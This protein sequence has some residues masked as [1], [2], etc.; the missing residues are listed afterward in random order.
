MK[1]L[2]NKLFFLW[3]A[4]VEY[5]FLF[6]L[7]IILISFSIATINIRKTPPSYPVRAVLYYQDKILNSVFISLKSQ[8]FKKCIE[9][10]SQFVLVDFFRSHEVSE[11]IF[12]DRDLVRTL[13]ISEWNPTALR[14]EKPPRSKRRTLISN[15]KSSLTGWSPTYVEP[16]VARLREKLLGFVTI[17]LEDSGRIIYLIGRTLDPKTTI[18]VM[19]VLVNAFNQALIM[20]CKAN[21]TNWG[22][23][24]TAVNGHSKLINRKLAKAINE[25]GLIDLIFDE[26]EIKIY[27]FLLSPQVLEI[28][29]TVSIKIYYIYSLMLSIFVFLFVYLSAK[30]FIF[31]FRKKWPV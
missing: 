28:S 19:D 21:L 2:K 11:I 8:E 14:F 29:R 12:E 18:K 31:P 7:F 5:S 23:E 16:N 1:H 20:K 3:H 22:E 26:Q 30:V 9:N 17:Y 24:K 27:D 10:Y 13:F 4:S 25:Y 15:L 6:F